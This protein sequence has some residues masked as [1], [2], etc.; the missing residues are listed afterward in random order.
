MV[1]FDGEGLQNQREG[2]DDQYGDHAHQAI[3][4]RADDRDLPDLAGYVEESG[5]RFHR[6]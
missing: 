3:A 5:H 1:T 6:R 4:D 2:P